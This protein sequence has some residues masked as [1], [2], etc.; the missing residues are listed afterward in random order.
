MTPWWS[1]HGTTSTGSTF[2]AILF[3]PD[4][5]EQARRKAADQHDVVSFHRVFNCTVAGH[6]A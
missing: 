4:G 1:I 5:E 2:A 3:A 6:P